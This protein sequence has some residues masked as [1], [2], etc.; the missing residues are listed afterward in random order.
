MSNEIVEFGFDDAKIIKNN[1]VDFFKQSKPGEKTR[2]S[3]VSF[4]KFSDVILAAKARDKGAAL[5]DAEKAEFISKIDHNLATQLGKTVEQLTEVDRLDIKQPR[6]GFAFTH[7]RDGVGSIRCHS[8]YEGS[9]VTKAELCCKKLGDADQ[10]VGSIVMTYPVKDG[11]TVDEELLAQKKYVNFYI[12]RMSSKKFNKLKEAYAEAKADD[13]HTLDLIVTLDGDPK[14]Q[15]QQIVPGSNAVWAR[16]AMN[17][18]TRQW[19]LDQGL[20]MWKHVPNSLGFD[21]K[22]DKLAEKLGQGGAALGSGAESAES[23]K[24]VSGYDSLISLR[25]L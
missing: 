23:P 3:I 1:A 25:L 12:W 20:R 4:K 2:V 8:E 19:V 15:K 13:R 21:M 24:L 5:S 14:Y 6:F 17:A 9:N 18:D 16:G 7:Y 10:T 22:M 11:M